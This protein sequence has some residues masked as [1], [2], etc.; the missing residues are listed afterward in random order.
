MIV[1]K[2]SLQ[3]VHVTAKDKDIPALDN[4]RMERDGT[5]VGA[6][7]NVVVAVAPVD[8]KVA[9]QVP[10]QNSG[11]GE[12][13][14]AADTVR[15]ALKLLGDKMFGGLLEHCDISVRG[16]DIVFT[17][18]DGKRRHTM[19]GRAYRHPYIPWQTILSRAMR[20]RQPGQR[21]V[22]NRA[23]LHLLLDTLEK[24]CPDSSGQSPVYLEFTTDG[25]IVCRARNAINGQRVVATMKNYALKGSAWLEEGEWERSLYAETTVNNN[26]SGKRL[27]VV[28]TRQ[29]ARR[30]R[31]V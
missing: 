7:G 8:P 14:I 29:I 6:A 21:V 5:M 23:R 12:A 30:L 27:R 2:S 20:N 22:L 15:K 18:T 19:D 9:A 17:F 4:V 3:A 24:V 28:H 11:A 25:D 26:N 31:R 16:E 10:L 1:S 13:T